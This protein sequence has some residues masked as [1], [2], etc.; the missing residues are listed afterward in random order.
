MLWPPLLI[1]SALFQRNHVLSLSMTWQITLNAVIAIRLS[2]CRYGEKASENYQSQLQQ[3]QKSTNPAP[4]LKKSSKIGPE[5]ESE[6]AER[7]ISSVIGCFL[8]RWTL[9]LLPTLILS[10][11]RPLTFNHWTSFVLTLLCSCF[12]LMIQQSPTVPCHKMLQ[13]P[14][15]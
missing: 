3:I 11:H 2:C 10:F 13:L 12:A 8:L 1:T 6:L 9:G 14:L 15:I 7:I 4:Y 5:S